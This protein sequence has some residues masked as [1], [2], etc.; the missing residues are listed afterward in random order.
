MKQFD[1]LKEN[2]LLKSV[3]SMHWRKGYRSKS[4]CLFIVSEGMKDYYHYYVGS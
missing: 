1:G 2:E 3:K 4:F